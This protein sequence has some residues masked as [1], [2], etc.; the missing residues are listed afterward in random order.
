M[1]CAGTIY[2]NFATVMLG[3]MKTD[4][5][6]GYYDVAI[7]IKTVLYSVISSLSTVLLPRAAYY[8]ENKME[9][10]FKRISEKAINF[11]FVAAVP[12][13]VYFICFAEECVFL[14]SG[15][16]FASSVLP[17]RLIM[18]ALLF[19]GLSGT[20]GIQ[21]LV[22]LGKEKVVLRS[23][24][25]GAVTDLIINLLL[26]PSM[27]SS[28]AAIGTLAAE[29]V[30]ALW[31]YA[32]LGDTISGAYR[33]VKYHTIIAA[34]AVGAAASLWVKGLGL[35]EFAALVASAALFFGA[36]AAVLTIAK[37]PLTL[38]IESQLL[39]KLKK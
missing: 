30:V 39:S 28:G 9:A 14:L 22:P 20:M 4:V 3:F 11:I 2:T 34:S 7:K 1:S 37:E 6:V 38:D 32:A 17:M 18:P 8:A 21:I 31:Q 23:Q 36:Y 33:R 15:E 16:A 35:G 29:A 27:A 12:L 24:I 10:D 19:A 5:D 13:V 26:I 25:A